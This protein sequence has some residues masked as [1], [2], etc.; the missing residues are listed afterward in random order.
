[1]TALD[2]VSLGVILLIIG[3]VCTGMQGPMNGRLAISTSGSFSAFLSFALGFWPLLIYFL[4]DTKGGKTVDWPNAARNAPGYAWLGGVF[5]GIFVLILTLVIHRRGAAITN[6]IIVVTQLIISVVID[7][8]GAFDTTQR[9]CT[10]LRGGGLACMI[11]Q[12][13]ERKNA[14]GGKLQI[15]IVPIPMDYSEFCRRIRAMEREDERK[16][17]DAKRREDEKNQIA[18]KT[19]MLTENIGIIPSA[20][21]EQATTMVGSFD[22]MTN[23][24]YND[25]PV[26]SIAQVMLKLQQCYDEQEYAPPGGIARHELTAE[27]LSNN[28]VCTPAWPDNFDYGVKV[29]ASLELDAVSNTTKF[30][31]SAQLLWH[32]DS[33]SASKKYPKLASSVVVDV[34]D[35]LYSI[36][37]RNS[38]LYAHIFIQAANNLLPHPNINDTYLVY[39]TTKLVHW[40]SVAKSDN[41]TNDMSPEYELVAATKV[42]WA[43]YLE[44]YTYAWMS[45]PAFVS[46]AAGPTDDDSNAGYTYKPPVLD[47]TFTETA[48]KVKQLALLHSNG[49]LVTDFDSTASV[50][51]KLQGVRRGWIIT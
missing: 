33:V 35:M 4:A 27:Y 42:P 38:T 41:S 16:L 22:Y 46:K 28:T 18:K 47:N 31:E 20:E 36:D 39:S 32:V 5:G 15:V 3:G 23:D 24:G 44:N 10:G 9:D 37:N 43:I 34:P 40:R 48:G 19:E 30:F 1:M 11:A 49:T 51:L 7:Q 50:Q 13:L 12:R 25:K 45:V 14:R 6:G 2:E 29:Y 8:A 26:E 21:N 17:A